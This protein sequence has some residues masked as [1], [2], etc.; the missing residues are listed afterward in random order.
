MHRRAFFCR[1]ALATCTVSRSEGATCTYLR[2]SGGGA[3]RRYS[4]NPLLGEGTENPEALPICIVGVPLDENSSF[5]RGNAE[6][7]PKI[8][9]KFHCPSSNCWSELGVEVKPP[10]IRDVGDLTLGSVDEGAM[11]TI[12]H[13]VAH[14]LVNGSLPCPSSSTSLPS[15]KRK[16]EV[17]DEDEGVDTKEANRDPSMFHKVVSLGGDHSISFPLVSAVSKK[18]NGNLSL[19]LIDAHA[20]MYADFEG[21]YYSHASPF[22]RILESGLVRRMVSLGMRTLPLHHRQQMERYGVECVEMKDFYSWKNRRDEDKL[23]KLLSFEE[24]IYLS[25]D[26]DGIDPAFAPGVSHQEPGGFSTREVIDLIHQIQGN[27]VAA[28]IVEYNPKR[29]VAGGMTGMLCAKLL[30]EIAG[31]MSLQ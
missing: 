27:I 12:E 9:E 11:K 26:I 10:L 18:Y 8:R 19:V 13:S 7:P 21:N 23:K 20:D 14:L 3:Q 29:D 28:D 15:A 5:M 4:S 6:A 22:A 25:V 17:V 16:S 2:L 24:P 30:R 1:Q 31:K